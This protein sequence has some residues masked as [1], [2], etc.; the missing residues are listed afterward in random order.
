MFL[1]VISIFSKIS[2]F[3]LD[4][5]PLPTIFSKLLEILV[6]KL[7]KFYST[8]FCIR[9]NMKKACSWR[10]LLDQKTVSLGNFNRKYKSFPLATICL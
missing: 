8:V 9:I 7:L 2:H 4:E 6:K 1:K 10:I 5:I 3:K